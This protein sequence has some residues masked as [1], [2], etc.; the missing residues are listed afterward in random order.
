MD[1]FDCVVSRFWGCLLSVRCSFLSTVRSD[2]AMPPIRMS[3]S[4]FAEKTHGFCVL[5]PL[6]CM[7]SGP[8]SR[9]SLLLGTS[10]TNASFCYF[11][12][13]FVTE[14]PHQVEAVEFPCFVIA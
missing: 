14:Y 12:F 10:W 9:F 1:R 5:L 8:A 6:R 7:P 13:I 2:T 11:T 3:F 4:H